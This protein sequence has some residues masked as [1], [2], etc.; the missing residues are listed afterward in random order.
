MPPEA[1]SG[2]FFRQVHSAHATN[3]KKALPMKLL[4]LL[5]A[6][7]IT[8]PALAAVYKTVRPDGSVVYSDQP[9]RDEAAPHPLPSFL[10]FLFVFFVF[11]SSLQDRGINNAPPADLYRSLTIAQP[12][13]DGTVRDPAGHVVVQVALDPPL[14]TKQGDYIIIS[15]DGKPVAQGSGTTYT[16]DDVERGTHTVEASVS[17]GPGQIL[18]RSPAVTFHIHRTSV[19]LP[20][21]R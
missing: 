9:P 19:N 12:E 5:L 3:A 7:S 18:I 1:I 20:S 6:F 10:L 11:V 17:S 2:A 15:L 16:L 4:A 13:A 14:I 21:R 8:T